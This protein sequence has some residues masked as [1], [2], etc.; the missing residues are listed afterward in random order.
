MQPRTSS[1]EALGT[2]WNIQVFDVL[3]EA[4]WQE[5]MTQVAARIADFD[6]TYSRFRD[7]SLVAELARRAGTYTLPDDA[8]PLL[9]FYKQLYEVSGGKVTPLIGQTMVA[10]GYDATYSFEPQTLYAPPEWDTVMEREGAT[11]TMKQPAL[12]DFGAAG[13][14]YTVDIVSELLAAAGLREYLIDAGGDILQRSN[15]STPAHIGLENPYDTSEAI[16]I[17]AITNQSICASASNKRAWHGMHHI[18]DPQQLAPVSETAAT[19]V[20]ADNTMLADGLATALFFVP[21]DT[22]RNHFAFEYALLDSTRGLHYSAGFPLT[23][24]EEPADA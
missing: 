19:W 7:D 1:F 10:A 6:A 17:A 8:L 12:L 4:L 14:G 18:I 21:A 24:F 13:K 23:L 15:S 16:G 9:E 2:H 5:L 20:V 22:L 3:S 11:L